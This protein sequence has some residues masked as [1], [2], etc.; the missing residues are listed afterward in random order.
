MLGWSLHACA[1]LRERF[2]LALNE[3]FMEEVDHLVRSKKYRVLSRASN[4]IMLHIES[5]LGKMVLVLDASMMQVITVYQ[6]WD[7]NLIDRAL[8]ES[9][10]L[11]AHI[12]RRDRRQRFLKVRSLYEE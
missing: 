9:E 10:R 1:R 2:V 4:R 8:E 11:S 3:D 5:S 7:M 6:P 12:R